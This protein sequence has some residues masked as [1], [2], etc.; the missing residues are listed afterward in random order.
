[1]TAFVILAAMLV[2]GALLLVVPPMLG[3]SGKRQIRARQRQAETA[4]VVLREQLAELETERAAGRLSDAEYERTREEIEL[5]ALEEG[6]AAEGADD[7]RPARA[8]AAAVALALPAAAVAFYVALGAPAAL[9]PQTRLASDDGHQ[10]TVEQM[11]GLVA[12]LAERLEREP[13]DTT[14]WLMLARSYAMLDMT[15]EAKA[16][17]QRIGAKVPDDPNVLADWADLLAS[18]PPGGFEGEPQ[19]LIERALGLEPDH[20]K[21][22]ALAGTSAYRANDFVGAAGYWERILARI[23]AGDDTR[24]QVLE[25]VNDA[26]VRAGLPPLE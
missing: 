20:V 14:G 13:A 25:S 24:G 19:R 17:W 12:Q 5:R 16:T 4:L 3:A 7:A 22:L 6:R 1:M 15:S 11:I 23:P 10:I 18:V 2:A 26:R 8:W 21:A 9:D